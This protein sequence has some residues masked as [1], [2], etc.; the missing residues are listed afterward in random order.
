[1]GYANTALPQPEPRQVEGIVAETR[2]RSERK[3]RTHYVDVICEGEEL[4]FFISM[5]RYHE[6]NEG[7]TVYVLRHEGALGAAFDVLEEGT[8]E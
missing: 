3:H 5:R 2:R 8:D 1:M 6:L 7:D 4:S